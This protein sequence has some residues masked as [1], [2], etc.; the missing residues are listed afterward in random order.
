MLLDIVEARPLEGYH[1]YLRFED[2]AEGVVDV[3][4]WSASRASLLLSVIRAN[5][6]A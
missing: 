2:G 3:S 4:A 6:P 5:L 1:V